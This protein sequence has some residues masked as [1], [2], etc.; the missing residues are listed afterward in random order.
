[1]DCAL[2]CGLCNVPLFFL[3]LSFSC[4]GTAGVPTMGSSSYVTNTVGAGCS[5]C[6]THPTISLTGMTIILNAKVYFHSIPVS[7]PFPSS[8]G[9]LRK[10]YNVL[11][12]LVI[13]P[14][15]LLCSALQPTRVFLSLDYPSWSRLWP[16][17][18]R[19]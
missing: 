15:Y 8:P 13:G 1:M 10:Y 17:C 11:V 16:Y 14:G 5:P 6:T 18:D 9:W 7:I 3:F 12:D 19:R 2:V 4:R